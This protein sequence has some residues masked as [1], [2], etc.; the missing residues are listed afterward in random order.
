MA[1]ALRLPPFS[2][3]IA[4]ALLPLVGGW[5]LWRSAN[6]QLPGDLRL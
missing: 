1:R 2:C 6:P 5:L 3:S 4:L